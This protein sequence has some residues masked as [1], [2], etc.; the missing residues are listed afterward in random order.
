L[1]RGCP[2]KRG[3]LKKISPEGIADGLIKSSNN[4]ANSVAQKTIQPSGGYLKSSHR[5]ITAATPTNH[6][7][8]V[9]VSLL[10]GRSWPHLRHLSWY[11]VFK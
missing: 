7:I 1:V 6:Q 10:S 11:L 3:S 9:G 8:Q 4:L 5:I 2:K